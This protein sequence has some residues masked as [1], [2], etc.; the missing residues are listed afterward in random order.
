MNKNYLLKVD[1]NNNI[2]INEQ[3]YYIEILVVNISKK[4]QNIKTRYQKFGNEE[5]IENIE[6][7]SNSNYKIVFKII[8][9]GKIQQL[10]QIWLDKENIKKLNIDKK[11]LNKKNT[12]KKL[13]RNPKVNWREEDDKISI[14]CDGKIFFLKGILSDIWKNSEKI[15]SI[16]EIKQNMNLYDNEYIEKA[17]NLMITKGVLI[18]YEE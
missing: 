2:I 7:D 8:K 5:L 9:D 11:I 13:S 6:L 3:L 1:L 18:E 16:D 12:M 14:Y 10:E 15:K 4:C 17:I